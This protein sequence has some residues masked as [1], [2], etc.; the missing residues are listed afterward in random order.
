MV[1][2]SVLLKSG[3]VY[4]IVLYRFKSHAT[5]SYDVLA[6]KIW[7][8][9]RLKTN[10]DITADKIF[11]NSSKSFKILIYDCDTLYLTKLD[12]RKITYV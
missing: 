10:C 12:V 9:R 3:N 8:I 4:C 6:A 1:I 5:L 7:S 2:T 11:V